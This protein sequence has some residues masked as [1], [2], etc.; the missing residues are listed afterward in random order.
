MSSKVKTVGIV[1]TGVIGS[2]WTALFLSHGWKALVSDPA[3]GADKALAEHLERMWPTMKEIGLD[4]GASLSNYK[5]VGA[6]LD[7]YY[8]QIDFIQEVR[9]GTVL[10]ERRATDDSP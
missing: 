5:F 3:P 6:T 7:G 1:G 2:S 8:D 10:R 9:P 4:S